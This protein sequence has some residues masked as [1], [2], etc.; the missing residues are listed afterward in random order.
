[1]NDTMHIKVA[2]SH[3]FYELCEDL[4]KEFLTLR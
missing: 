4:T 3:N 1:M 2:N